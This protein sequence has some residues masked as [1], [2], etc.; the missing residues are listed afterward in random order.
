[1][2]LPA[3]VDVVSALEEARQREIERHNRNASRYSVMMKH[4][5][6]VATYLASQGLAFRGQSE[7]KDS[8]NRG[9]CLELMDVLGEYSHE[10]RTFRDKERITYTS[11]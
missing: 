6:D 3:D 2:L 5:I 8:A 1:M 10:L 7:S 4:H 9:N 11:H